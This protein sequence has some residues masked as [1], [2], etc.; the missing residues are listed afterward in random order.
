MAY[1][2]SKMTVLIV[3]DNQS[4]ANITRDILRTFGFKS[5]QTAENGETG[6]T[7]FCR[8][9]HDLLIIDWMMKP[10]NGL[11]LTEKI[12][13]NSAS[14]NKLVP[15]ILMTGISEK[16][17]VLEARD[18]GVTEFMLKP[19]T[20][21]DLYKRLV[22]I[23][24]RPRQFVKCESFFGPDRRRRRAPDFHGPEK[25]KNTDDEV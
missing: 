17:K 5:I 23:I 12:R 24:E 25:R 6:F 19:F 1:D 22:Q 4:L 3:E 21:G 14:P 16:A 7:R 15:I 10:V 18:N 2:F 9:K 11:E 20:A 8:G 13:T